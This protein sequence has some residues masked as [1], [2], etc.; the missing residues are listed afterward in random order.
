MEKPELR[1]NYQ[2]LCEIIQAVDS[3]IATANV[4]D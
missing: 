4:G 3:H 1:E 2:D